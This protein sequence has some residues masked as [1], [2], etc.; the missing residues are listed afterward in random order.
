MIFERT[1]HYLHILLIFI[2]LFSLSSYQGYAQQ[3]AEP[4][5]QEASPGQTAPL[6]TEEPG[7]TLFDLLTAGGWIM[8]VL[9]LLSVLALSL[10]IYYSFTL[11]EKR[12]VPNDIVTQ[13]RHFV[14]EGRF[15]DV[16]RICRR[17]KGMFS[18]I[19][20]SGL[21][22]G[23][24]DPASVAPTMEAVGRRE[25]ERL[26]R[27]VRYL[28]DIAQIA[29]M[30]GLLGTVLGMIEAFNF[31][32][33]DISAVKPVALASAVAKALVTTAA[34]LIVAIPCMGFFFYFRGRLQALIGRVEEV[35]VEVADRISTL[36]NRG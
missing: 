21:S 9:G 8:V 5:I 14:R 7:M 30:L 27:Q 18:K 2:F 29:P 13:I 19:I 3:A 23:A 36:S 20:L 26:M 25:A 34:G 12:I 10:V 24:N 22:R 6:T 15:D 28:S 17:S 16:A 35:A 33:F 1:R 32:A 11:T 31:I 4:Q